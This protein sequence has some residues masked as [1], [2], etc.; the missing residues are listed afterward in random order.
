VS[1]ERYVQVLIPNPAHHE[2]GYLQMQ[3]SPGD[4]PGFRVGL[5]PVTGVL[6]REKE[7]ETWRCREEAR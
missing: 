2:I 3:L 5:N 1:P 7:R 6:L 4:H